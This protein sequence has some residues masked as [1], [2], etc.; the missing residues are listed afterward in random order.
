MNHFGSLISLIWRSL[1]LSK[2]PKCCR[3]NSLSPSWVFPAS[4]QL[5][6]QYKSCCLI[7][8]LQCSKTQHGVCRSAKVCEGHRHVLQALYGHFGK[9]SSDIRW[10]PLAAA[11]GQSRSSSAT[12]HA[13]KSR[14][15]CSG[16]HW[17]VH[18]CRWV[19][20]ESRLAAKRPFLKL[21]WILELRFRG[22]CISLEKELLPL[23]QMHVPLLCYSRFAL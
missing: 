10:A 14:R 19:I 8:S 11:A 22:K 18:I 13:W 7:P 9:W 12:W 21:K 15:S 20:D 1:C 4:L 16:S 2:V 6:V 5:P 3:Q 17:E 23:C